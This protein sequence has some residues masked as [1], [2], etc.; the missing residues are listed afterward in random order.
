MVEDSE[1]VFF[2]K[3]NMAGW[4]Y[5]SRP[6]RMNALSAQS[7][8]DIWK[9]LA[10]AEA[11]PEVRALVFTGRGEAFCAGMDMAGLESANPMNARRRSREI[12]MLTCRI[13]ELPLPTVAAVNGV[14]M[15]AG[16]E[17]CLACDLDCHGPWAVFP[18]RGGRSGSRCKKRGDRHTGL[19][20]SRG[21]IVAFHLLRRPSLP[22]GLESPGH[23]RVSSGAWSKRL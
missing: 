3:S 12:Q 10:R 16:L 9:Q 4:I 19:R 5:L 20:G 1:T 15:G 13:S 21:P 18:G 17:I 2:E 11:D 22:H 8:R 23:C 6:G 14:A 7:V